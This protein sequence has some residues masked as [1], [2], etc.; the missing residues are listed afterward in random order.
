LGL[1]RSSDELNFEPIRR[2]DLDDGSEITAT[3]AV[4]WQI[5]IEDDSIE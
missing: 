3:E 1:S 5:S 4:L 2:V